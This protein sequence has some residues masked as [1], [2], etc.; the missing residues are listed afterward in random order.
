[1]QPALPQ[2]RLQHGLAAAASALRWAIFC[3][4]LDNEAVEVIGRAW[5]ARSGRVVMLVVAR[6]LLDRAVCLGMLRDAWMLRDATH[7]RC[8]RISRRSRSRDH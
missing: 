8:L 5:V 3:R 4:R 6:R 7:S 2:Q 1:M